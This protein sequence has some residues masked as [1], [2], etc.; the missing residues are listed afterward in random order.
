VLATKVEAVWEPVDLKRNS[1][2]E[3]DIEYALQVKAF[4]GR[5]LM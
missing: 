2:L 4:S 1:F 5:R 3:R